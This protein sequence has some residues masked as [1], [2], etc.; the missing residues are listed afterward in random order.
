MAL[1]RR[2]RARD[3]QL[4]SIGLAIK[5]AEAIGARADVVESLYDLLYLSKGRDM[6]A[7]DLRTAAARC[8][9]RVVA[10]PPELPAAPPAP[11]AAGERPRRAA[12]RTISRAGIAQAGAPTRCRRRRR[13]WGSSKSSG[14]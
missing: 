1:T 11:A 5:V 13:R 9:G 8:W 12:Q 3:P 7:S 4:W 14:R 10:L 2:R 6:S